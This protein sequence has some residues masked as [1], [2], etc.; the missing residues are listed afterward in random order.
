MNYALTLPNL[1]DTS[2]QEAKREQYLA[3]AA[4]RLRYNSPEIVSEALFRDDRVVNAMQD[5]ILTGGCLALLEL[6]D[7]VARK[8]VIDG[9]A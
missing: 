4:A 3:E 1:I 6:I 7:D 2:E 5:V 8:I 9:G